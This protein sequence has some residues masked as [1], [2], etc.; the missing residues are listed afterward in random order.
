MQCVPVLVT[1]SPP[2]CSAAVIHTFVVQVQLRRQ[3]TT[4][5]SARMDARAATRDLNHVCVTKS[6]CAVPI[7]S[8]GRQSDRCAPQGNDDSVDEN[9]EACFSPLSILP[10]SSLSRL[11]Y[12]NPS[13]EQG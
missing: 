5:F 8:R 13:A 4:I 12:S 6:G 11:T 2:L 7:P 1:S 3:S 10:C 9:L